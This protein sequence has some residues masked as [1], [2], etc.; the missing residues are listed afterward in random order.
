MI[1]FTHCLLA[2]AIHMASRNPARLYGMNDRGEIKPGKR[3]DLILFTIEKN[4]IVI[5][6]TIIMGKVVYMDEKN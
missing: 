6:K 4:N 2:D 3:A 1:L 5:K